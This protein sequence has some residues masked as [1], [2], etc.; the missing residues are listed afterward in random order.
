M[1]NQLYYITHF[2][3]VKNNSVVFSQ[4]NITEFLIKTAVCEN[5]VIQ[6]KLDLLHHQ[7][8]R[9]EDIGIEF[10]NRMICM[11]IGIIIFGGMAIIATHIVIMTISVAITVVLFIAKFIAKLLF[12]IFFDIL[13]NIWEL[14]IKKTTFHKSGAKFDTRTK[15]TL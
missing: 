14:F 6:G 12:D 11:A 4:T 1:S 2:D 13:F 5:L 9:N 10:I 7:S 8:D 15:N 3:G